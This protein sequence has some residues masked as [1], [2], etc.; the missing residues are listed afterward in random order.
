M[1]VIHQHP[2]SQ[3]PEVQRQTLLSLYAKCV[4]LLHEG[5]AHSRSSG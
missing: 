3:S 1:R 2:A 4:R 5:R